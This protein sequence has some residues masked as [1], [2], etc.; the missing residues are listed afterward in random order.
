MDSLFQLQ[1][2]SHPAD[3]GN[4]GRPSLENFIV[5][6]VKFGYPA[7]SLST[8]TLQSLFLAHHIDMVSRRAY[9]PVPK[10]PV[11]L[12]LQLAF[13]NEVR[14]W[15]LEEVHLMSS[16]T[17]YSPMPLVLQRSQKALLSPSGIH[18]SP[19]LPQ[20]GTMLHY[21][22]PLK[23]ES[24]ATPRQILKPIVHWFTP[25]GGSKL[26]QWKASMPF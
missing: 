26:P 18:G 16:G 1:I 3:P 2:C 14:L 24:G 6:L 7:G 5:S 13:P 10:R 25:Q 20:I 23:V 15:K 19:G 4:N 21:K 8:C 11:I 22:M 12:F 17:C 9:N